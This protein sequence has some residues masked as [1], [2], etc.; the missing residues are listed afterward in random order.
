[1]K[2]GLFGGTFDPVHFGHLILADN[3]REYFNLNR[4]IFIPSKWPPH[5]KTCFLTEARLRLQMLKSAIR[6][7]SFFSLSEIELEREG[8]SY[9]FDT[10][11]SFRQRYRRKDLFFLMGSD[12]L[13]DI[14]LWYRI[15]ELV[16]ECQFILIERPGFDLKEISHRK[17]KISEKA[18]KV[19]TAHVFKC[20]P[21]DIS[22]REIR[23]R[24]ADG[25]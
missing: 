25:R 7:Q 19:L 9:S 20:N 24:V 10:V 11:C 1:M 18:F 21:V 14:H 12:S 13:L 22:S 3:V 23:K 4:I 5:K 16:R 2:I 15:E 6:G 8:I 17:L